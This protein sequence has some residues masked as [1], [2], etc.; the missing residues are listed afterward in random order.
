MFNMAKSQ[1]SMKES[2]YDFG[3]IHSWGHTWKINTLALQNQQL[4]NLYIPKFWVNYMKL[5]LDSVYWLFLGSNLLFFTVLTCW[6]HVY[7]D[8][9]WIVALYMFLI[10]GMR[11]IRA[12]FIMRE[13]SYGEIER[14][15]DHSCNFIPTQ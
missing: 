9:V 3:A 4:Q 2:C 6:V 8:R 14:Y 13:E 7:L 10:C 5:F 11:H 1:K 15:L 12:L